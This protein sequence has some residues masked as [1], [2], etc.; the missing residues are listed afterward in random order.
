MAESETDDRNADKPFEETP[1]QLAR[2]WLGQI[3]TAEK[4]RKPFITRGKQIVRRYKGRRSANTANL[5][6]LDPSGRKMN[7]LWSNVQTQQPVLFAQTPKA[8]VSRR[9]KTKD[10]VGRTAS[11]VLQNCLQ[12]SMGMEDFDFIMSQV[13]QDRLL[14]GRGEVMVEYVPQIADDKIGWQAAETRYVPWTDT[15][16]NVARIPQEVWFWGYRTYLTKNEAY[17]AALNGSKTPEMP[18]GDEEFA[19]HVRTNITLDHKEDKEK[20]STQEPQAKATVWCIWDKNKKQ[21]LHIAPGYPDAPLAVMPPPVSFDDFFPAPRPLQAT[22]ATDST[23]PVADFDQYVDQADE[24]DLMT[25]RIGVLTKAL[26]LR[27]M[28]PADMDAIKQ[29]MESGSA[30]LIPYDNWQMISERGGLDKLVLWFPLEA[31]AATLMHCYE[32]RE[33]SLAIMYQ[34]TGISDIMRGDTAPSETLGAQ[35]LKAQFGGVRVRESQKDVQRFIRDILRKKSEIICEHFELEVIKKMSGVKLLMKAEKQQ[36]EL[37]KQKLAQFDA[38]QKAIAQQATAQGLPAPPPAQS[39]IPPVPEEIEEMMK[40]PTWEEVMALLRDE[41]L[42]GFVVDV[43]TDSTIEPDQQ[44]QQQAASEFTAAVAQFLSAALPI[45]QASPDTADFLG[46]MLIWTTQRWKGADTIESA[47]E[48]FVEKLKKQAEQPKGP[49]PE[50]LKAQAEVMKAQA[51]VR[52][53]EIGVE[54]KTLELQ[55]SQVE[56]QQDM[57]RLAFEAANPQLRQQQG[58]Q[59]GGYPNA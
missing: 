7:V 20:N 34:L 6:T 25:Q 31:I 24:V 4:K 30:D 3:S 19:Q 41:K 14:P 38:Q 16:T 55:A 59:N 28:Y 17:E 45:V 12:N 42:R 40:E 26:N 51:S 22:T 33:Q 27:G 8:N 1:E 13:V 35:Q 10:P 50:E 49:G 18:E 44:A 56:H 53:A 15:I 48:E 37:V 2:Y 32:V 43:E 58:P 21:V 36:V 11:I 9:N 29:L 5:G 57:E 23:I 39:G 47:V 52:V 54:Q 46:E